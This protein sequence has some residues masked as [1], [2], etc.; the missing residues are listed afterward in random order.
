MSI[1]TILA[2]STLVIA[3]P[4]SDKDSIDICKSYPNICSPLFANNDKQE[5]L[6]ITDPSGKTSVIIY[7][8]GRVVLGENVKTDQAARDFWKA[9]ES[10]A[11]MAHCK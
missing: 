5:A 9:I 3:P 7:Q 1:L 10:F 6:Y 2:A 8:D 4:V 11:P